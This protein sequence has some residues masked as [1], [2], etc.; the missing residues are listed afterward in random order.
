MKNIILFLLLNTTIFAYTNDIT[1]LIDAMPISI[2]HDHLQQ[3]FSLNI[4][5]NIK[6]TGDIVNDYNFNNIAPV[7][8]Y[9]T[10][11]IAW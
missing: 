9:T 10:I 4:N 11:K 6:L 7:K 2:I 8:T 3:N 1:P 5:T